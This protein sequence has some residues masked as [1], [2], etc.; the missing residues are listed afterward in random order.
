MTVL[1]TKRAMRSNDLA[2]VASPAVLSWYSDR[3]FRRTRKVVRRL[4]LGLLAALFCPSLVSADIVPPKVDLTT[5]TGVSIPDV[6]Y[7]INSTD[8]T[9]GSLTLERFTQ[10]PS[11]YWPNYPQFGMLMTSNFDIYVQSIVI[12]ASGPPY[13]TVAHRHATVHIGNAAYGTYYVSGVSGS[14]STISAH[15]SDAYAGI[16]A[17]SGTGYKFTDKQGSEYF[18]TPSVSANPT[19]SGVNYGTPLPTSQRVDHI[20]LA[21]GRVWQFYY[22]ASQRVKLVTDS[23][24][25]AILFDYG[26][27]GFVADACAI[28][29]A[30]SYVTVASTCA[31][32]PL[33]VSYQYGSALSFATPVTVLSAFTDLRGQTTSY[34]RSSSTPSIACVVPPGA[35]TCQ[36]QLAL[37]VQ[38]MADGSIWHISSDQSPYA[39]NDPEVPQPS[40]Y[41]GSVIDPASKT[42]SYTFAG[43][44]PLSVTDANSKTTTFKWCCSQISDAGTSPTLDGSMLVEADFPEGNKYT[45]YY[46][47]FNAIPMG[48]RMQAKPGSGLA[49]QVVTRSFDAT[50]ASGVAVA[51]PTAQTDPNG[52]TTNW[53]YT[54]FGE[55]ATE[56]APAPTSGAAR[57]LKVTTYVQKYA[58]VL[59][60]GTLVPSG[61]PLWMISTETQCQTVAGSST[62]TCDSGAPQMVTTY[63]YGA[64]GTVDNLLLRGVAATA[65]GQ[66]RRTCYGYDSYS[67]KI[68]TTTPRAGSAACS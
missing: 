30:R 18:F 67:R 6:E 56:M 53:T 64:D 34:T 13:N 35:S 12:K 38:T 23:R 27:N 3:F 47:P 52:N 2:I 51:K 26:A 62:P 17:W 66:T 1:K 31:G 45:A 10:S 4:V 60:G 49:D 41:G 32:Q 55:V 39:V 65:D 58:Y 16:L 57:P 42:T 28:D 25:Y 14:P 43:S 15:N 44:S 5:P 7:R 54:N 48:E 20:N 24:G 8:I 37:G 40:S 22:D 11:R 29:S 50:L 68:S 9:L 36:M 19:V 63:E 46:G 33:T 59:S 21:D 61:G